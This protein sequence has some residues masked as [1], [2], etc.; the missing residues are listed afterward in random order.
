M[1]QAAYD[2][3]KMGRTYA[4]M[5]EWWER[6]NLRGAWNTCGTPWESHPSWTSPSDRDSWHRNWGELLNA[7]TTAH[8]RVVNVNGVAQNRLTIRVTHPDSARLELVKSVTGG[9]IEGASGPRTVCRLQIERAA[10]FQA[11]KAGRAYV[12]PANSG[13]IE[14]LDAT[15]RFY[16]HVPEPGQGASDSQMAGQDYWRDQLDHLIGAYS[17]SRRAHDCAEG[18][19]RAGRADWSEAPTARQDF[20]PFA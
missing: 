15:M 19:R 13:L 5:R 3:T 18:I 6:E 16:E 17:T 14:V 4:A 7:H 12:D 9:T 20:G 11:L 2:H 8:I 10:A 1:A